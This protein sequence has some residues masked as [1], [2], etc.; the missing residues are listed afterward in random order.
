MIIE[1]NCSNFVSDKQLKY[2]MKSITNGFF[3]ELNSIETITDT[4]YNNF[5]N[6]VNAFKSMVNAT[7]VAIYLF[8]YHKKEIPFV[9]KN[10]LSWCG[11]SAEDVNKYGYDL[12]LK[13]IPDEDLQMLIDINNIAFD[14]FYKSLNN[15]CNNFSLSYDFRFCDFMVNQHYVPVLFKDNKIWVAAC[16]VFPSSQKE[17]G[18]MVLTTDNG[19]YNYSFKNKTWTKQSPIYL[20]DREKYIIRRSAQGYS[21]K[22]IAEINH[23]CETTVKK[24]KYILFEKL[25]VSNISEAV[26]RCI[27]NGLL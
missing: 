19:S 7:N 6:F 15:E 14:Y 13:F 4:D 9:S 16:Y 8:D 18:N 26:Q 11:I 17:V 24:Q 22:E 5:E 10:I 27:T 1:K 20:S 25:G 23:I 12:I 21:S 3:T 2:A